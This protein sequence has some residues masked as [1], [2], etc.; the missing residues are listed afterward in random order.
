MAAIYLD[1]VQHLPRLK[2]WLTSPL[3]TLPRN[4]VAVHVHAGLP[5]SCRDRFLGCMRMCEAQS[6]SAS[7]SSLLSQVSE[8]GPH[9]EGWTTL[10]L[11]FTPASAVSSH[12]Q[13]SHSTPNYI[14]P[15]AQSPIPRRSR[16]PARV[17]PNKRGNSQNTALCNSGIFLGGRIVSFG[18][19]S[20]R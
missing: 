8:S 11:L 15:L 14:C 13:N 19:C 1:N 9:L 6:R 20:L 4:K 2:T 10:S 7:I 18:V 16:L 12:P 3:G 5:L 17:Y